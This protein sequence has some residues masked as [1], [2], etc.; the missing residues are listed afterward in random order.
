MKYLS[1]KILVMCILA[2]PV[3]YI[4]TVLIIENRL[5]HLYADELE[6]RFMGDSQALLSGND[7]LK[8]SINKNISGYLEKKRVLSWGVKITI[9]V[10]TKNGSPLYP[11]SFEETGDAVALPG[12]PIKIAEENFKLMSEGL[13]LDLDVSIDHNTPLSNIVL[14]FYILAS[15]VVM[16]LYYRSG[17]IIANKVEHSFNKEIERL[18]TLSS[19]YSEKMRLLEQ[20][21]KIL[22]EKFDAAKHELKNEKQKAWIKS[23]LIAIIE[24][25]PNTDRLKHKG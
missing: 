2:P 7:R 5:Q 10:A 14:G 12:D 8:N 18:K 17:L 3:L 19:D 15:L 16:V 13:V 24:Y 21:R 22:K 25:H 9:T 23:R 4:V 11:V 20:K 6:G 1:L